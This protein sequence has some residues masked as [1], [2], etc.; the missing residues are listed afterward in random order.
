M[1]PD[2]GS[3]PI[4]AIVLVAGLLGIRFFIRESDLTIEKTL[5]DGVAERFRDIF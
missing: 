3:P 1:S 2:D 4:N 5:L